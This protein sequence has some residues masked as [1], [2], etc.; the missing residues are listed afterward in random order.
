MTKPFLST[1][2]FVVLPIAAFAAGATPTQT[3]AFL[4]YCKTNS[5]GCI[6]KV[7]EI[8]FAV[9]IMEPINHKA[10]PPAETD[11]AK[12]LTSRVVQWLTAHSE[13]NGETTDNGIQIA[14]SKLYPCKG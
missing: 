13:T 10:C 14:L 3:G 5:Q 7:T 9:M 2:C 6:D 11:D 8:K 4:G 12:A 1:L